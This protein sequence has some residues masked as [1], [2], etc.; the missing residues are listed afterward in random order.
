MIMNFPQCLKESPII[1]TEGS[2]VERLRRDS[3]FSLDPYIANAGF[4]Y[5]SEQKAALKKIYTEYI[6]IGRKK[7]LPI[8]LF[9]PTWRANPERL[10]L[11]GLDKKDV[12]GDCYRFLDEIRK[13]YGLYA[14]R[15]FIGGLMGC[16]GDAYKPGEALGSDDAAIFHQTQSHALAQAGV[17]FLFAATLPAFSEAL[18]M[19]KAMSKTGIPYILSF[20]VRA[21]GTLLDGTPLHEAIVK[22][23]SSI[24]PKPLGFMVNCVHPSVFQQAISSEENSS[25]FVRQRILGLQANTSKKRPEELD[26]SA[27]LDTE[28]PEVFGELMNGLN[29]KFGMKILGGCCGT[30]EKHIEAIVSLV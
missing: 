7:N 27:A 5:K 10:K 30:D 17:D 2:V 18:G 20:V 19:A 14:S 25:E 1:I 4:I 11:A 12:N 22:I 15:I 13:E 16:K 6:E 28:D 29:K 9:T 21:E 26:G 8:I 24:L 23:D 3:L